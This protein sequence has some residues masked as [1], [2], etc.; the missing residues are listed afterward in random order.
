M[1][2]TVRILAAVYLCGL[3][4]GFTSLVHAES[5]SDRNPWPKQLPALSV[6]VSL[7]QTEVQCGDTLKVSAVVTSGGVG[8]EGVYV[9]F[10]LSQEGG[11][12][13]PPNTTTDS[14]GKAETVLTTPITQVTLVCSISVNAAKEGYESAM[15]TTEFTLLPLPKL[16][17]SVSADSTQ[18]HNNQSVNL[19]VYVSCN[20]QPVKGATV[21]MALA[22]GLR[23][24]G[25]EYFLPSNGTTNQE[26]KF[27]CVFSPPLVV[28]ETDFGVCVSAY[29]DGYTENTSSIV[30]KVVPEASGGT[31]QPPP[32]TPDY[33][34][35]LAASM[36]G[37]ATICI[38]VRRRLWE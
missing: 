2:R 13:N 19:T 22:M 1:R 33:T 12:F 28:N 38:F 3:L 10:W 24:Y 17:I 25:E 30:I 4:L 35:W 9:E 5:P 15:N 23:D 32:R 11:I 8:V 21:R 27:F 20:N 36:I 26:G 14:L 34:A 18:I 16:E 29:A 6:Q 31:N 7:N 37:I